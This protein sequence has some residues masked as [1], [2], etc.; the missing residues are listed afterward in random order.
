MFK[1]FRG[2]KRKLG[3]LLLVG[4][5]LTSAFWIRSL[6]CHD[7]VLSPRCAVESYRGGIYCCFPGSSYNGRTTFSSDLITNIKL[8]EPYYNAYQGMQWKWRWAGFAYNQDKE[9]TQNILTGAVKEI[10]V[11]HYYVT[12]WPFI[13]VT[14][15][16]SAW[17]LVSKNEPAKLTST[18]PGERL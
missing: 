15:M 14:A 9:V 5:C 17:L 11:R 2:W 16:F 1:Y 7:V 4:S 3:L 8:D 13:V 10:D 6:S 12:Y 18:I